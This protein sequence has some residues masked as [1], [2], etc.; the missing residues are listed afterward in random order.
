MILE[1]KS[2]KAPELSVIIVNWNS[3]DYVIK[4]LNSLRTHCCD[5]D[6]EVIVIDGASFDGCDIALKSVHPKSTFVQSFE[7]VGFG[8]CNNE[9]SNQARGQYILLLNPDTEVTPNSIQ[10]LLKTA[11]SSK[12]TGIVGAKLLNTDGTFQTSS[13]L[14]Y[15]TALNQALD[16]NFIKNHLPILNLWKTREAYTTNSVSQVEAISGACMLMRKDTFKAIGGFT[17][18]YFMYSEDVDLC[19]KTKS[20]GLDILYNPNSIIVHHGGGSSSTQ[21]SEFSLIEFRKSTHRFLTL[22]KSKTSANTFTILLL[23][24]SVLRILALTIS[25]PLSNRVS[26]WQSIKKWKTTLIW[27][28]TKKERNTKN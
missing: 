12:T 19:Y 17:Q 25:Y 26:C 28:L 4:C 8:R 11:K 14:A 5:I 6:Y 3:K 23:L 1:G 2:R 22:R 10:T 9:A 18:D 20:Y 13:V 27:C 24:S 15:P 21:P 7:N 16:S